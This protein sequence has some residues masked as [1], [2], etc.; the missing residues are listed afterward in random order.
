M[1]AVVKPRRFQ[2][3]D[4][5]LDLSKKSYLT[6]PADAFAFPHIDVLNLSENRLTVLPAAVSSFRSLRV[7]DLRKNYLETFPVPI[8]ELKYLRSLDL[9]FNKISSISKEIKTLENL[10]V[11]LLSNNNFKK[12]PVEV[13][14]VKGLEKLKLCNCYIDSIPASVAQL[15][16]LSELD[17]SGNKVREIAEEICGN[18]NLATLN[19]ANN[20]LEKLPSLLSIKLTKLDQFNVAGNDIREPP[21]DVCERGLAAVREYQER[22]Q[23]RATVRPSNSTYLSRSCDK[24]PI[25]KGFVAIIC[26]DKFSSREA[27]PGSQVDRD[28]L[29]DAFER[30]PF[31]VQVFSNLDGDEMLYTLKLLRK[32]EQEI[33]CLIIFVLTHATM[34][35]AL[36]SDCKYISLRDIIKIFAG[37]SYPRMIGRP[38]LFFLQGFQSDAKDLGQF[39][40]PGED[41]FM[42]GSAMIETFEGYRT[43]TQKSSP[44]IESMCRFIRENGSTNHIAE[45]MTMVADDMKTKMYVVKGQKLKMN[46][47]LLGT[48]TKQVWL[49]SY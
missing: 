9:S 39:A 13:C 23:R 17:L 10:T 4:L 45:I 24:Y 1:A 16:T 34:S 36:G 40:L 7:L 5:V 47:V 12:F 19:L 27:R 42:F 11:L 44:Y 3:G 48:L 22:Q 35:S 29:K 2:N 20:K 43:A 38:K 28:L 8:L 15:R 41:D 46:T 14:S 32:M 21:K 25:N 49:K 37:D 6:I 30:Y 18:Q 26:N 33:D 31:Q